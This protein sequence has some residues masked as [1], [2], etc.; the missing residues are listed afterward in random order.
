MII[1]S[2][3]K[4]A[5]SEEIEC[6]QN[7]RK[8]KNVSVLLKL[9]LI[10]DAQ[11]LLR[12]G[13]HIERGEVTNQEK[14]PVILPSQHHAKTLIVEHLHQGR[15]FTQGI[16]RARGYWTIDGQQLIDRVMYYC[17]K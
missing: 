17:L 7:E 3:Q 15:H 1:K 9:S 2:L 13:G 12:V 5:Y 14:H 11:G 8:T 4:E 10:I 16:A 6:I